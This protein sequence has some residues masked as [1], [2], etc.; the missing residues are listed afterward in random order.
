M[1]TF[2]QD[3][4][5]GIRTLAKNPG[6]A[7][8]AILTLALGI[9]AST[10]IFSVVDA[11]LLRPLPYPNPQQIVRV[12]EQ[13]P[14]G[15]MINLADP[16]FEDFRAQNH[17]L[18]AL[19]EYS[20][21]PDSVS[22][23]SEPVRMNVAAVSQDFFKCLGVEPFRGRAFAPDEQVFQGAPAI[24]VSYGYWRQFL[25]GAEDLSHVR[26]SMDGVVYPVVGVMPQ[27]FDFPAGVA[28][29]VPRESYGM[30][31]SRTGHSG[32]GLGRVRDG[33]TVAQARSDLDSIARRIRA[34]Y[35]EKVDLTDAAVV[36]LADAMVANARTA[37]LTILG[38]VALL[39]LVA[40][41]NVAGLLLARTAAR[42]KEFAVRVALGAGPGR[43]IQQL[44]S[45]SFVLSLAGGAL[46]VLIALWTVKIL[47]AILATSLP[48]QEGIAVNTPVLL[49]ALAATIA[50]A[51]SLG[52]VAAWRASSGDPQKALSAGSRG[53]SGSGSNHRLRSSLVA[54]EIAA[55]LV[56]LI[57]A[58]L[59]GRTFLRLISV[60]VGF[61]QETLTTM[62]FSPPAPQDQA[63]VVRQIQFLQN[64]MSRVRTIPGVTSAGLATGLPVV[65]GYADG[66]FM[67]LGGHKPPA[68]FDEWN[69]IGR[70]LPSGTADYCVASGGYFRAAGIPLIRGRLFNEQDGMNTVNVALISQTLARQQWPKQDPIGQI[71][72]FGNM[73]G[74][75][76]PL[77]IVGV[78]GDVR[79]EGVDQPPSA[80]IYT[81]YA[82]R[83][84]GL[85]TSP[86]VILHSAAPA[87]EVISAAR[88]I[89]HQLD[90]NV[91]VKFSTFADELGGWFAERRF[92][93]LLM[94]FFAIAALAL[95]A[96]GVYGVVAFSVTRRTQEIGIR[97]A[98]GARRSDVLQLIIGEGARLAAIG[99]IIGVVASLA[100]TPLM[101]SLLF[102]IRPTDPE[103]FIGV[104]LLLS[105]V[106][107]LASYIPARR[108]M[109]LDPTEALRYE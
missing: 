66:T 64:A 43:L 3:L 105:L 1:N 6:F 79:A 100:I 93:L 95:A 104:A 45:E 40:C 33:I 72:E 48:R 22:G 71:I 19:A 76:K 21:G 58:G 26:L 12:W 65:D 60:S 30:N 90:P 68:N 86:T 34:Q 74:N 96:V 13:T 85:N 46:G 39:F 89:F 50:V 83:G 52:L 77:T 28:A 5:F 35:G 69:R 37:L 32:R 49:F 84:L 101:S 99:V 24:I 7:V 11:V 23:G 106:A 80:I 88:G 78:V 25:G 108:A 20:S 47:P 16:N 10:A 109:R 62:Q 73:D 29:W 41:A 92:T 59:L 9:G 2:L 4:R 70:T 55:S 61:R 44:L 67:V 8:V 107:L 94:G 14:G 53:F 103:T 98:L 38:G 82:Q 81:D 75:L 56:I 54:G 63:G 36:P 15:H 97:M 87:G 31:P 51:I 42:R 27:G 91:P 17:T 57:G 102:E 18:S